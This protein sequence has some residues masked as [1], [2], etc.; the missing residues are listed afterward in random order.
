MS[1]KGNVVMKKIFLI[2]MVIVV[3]MIWYKYTEY[4]EV[5]NRINEY[6][7][8]Y[9][10]QDDVLSKEVNYD[11]KTGDFYMTVYYKKYPERIYEYFMSQNSIFGIAYEQSK[12]IETEEYLEDAR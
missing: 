7:D 1:E 12:E 4:S 9:N 8:E 3:W 11:S 5:D 2:V 6:L 10:Y